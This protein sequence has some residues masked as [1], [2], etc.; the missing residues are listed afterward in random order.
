MYNVTILDKITTE[1]LNGAEGEDTIRHQRNGWLHLHTGFEGKRE[2]FWCY[3]VRRTCFPLGSR[4]KSFSL[5]ARLFSGKGSVL[6][7]WVTCLWY[8]LGDDLEVVV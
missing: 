7:P 3:R 8:S 5:R 1:P 2:T 4:D 6:L